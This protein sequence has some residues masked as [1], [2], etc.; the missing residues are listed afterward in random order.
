MSTPVTRRR[1]A[2]GLRLLGALLAAAVILFPL[3]WMVVVAFSTRSSLSGGGLRLWPEQATLDNFRR[4]LDSFPVLTWFGNSVAIALVTS[5]IIVLV[6]LLA[7]YAFAHLR[8]PGSGVLLL[9]ALSTLML[10]VQVIMVGLFRL[11]TD[12][13]LYGS[14][15]AVILPTAASAFG[16][17]LARQFILTIPRELIEAAR[18]DGATHL[19][20]FWRIVLPL[21]RPLIAVLFFMS[22]LQ[23]WNDFAWPLI[24]L[25]EN[26]LY[27]LPV[28]LLF[29]QGQFG[30]DY[31]A[32][33]A[34][35]L[36]TVA[37]MVLV[38]LLAQRWFVQG[39]SRSGLR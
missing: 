30:P 33:M 27:T 35:A 16:V 38:F 5:V 21:S 8:F 25:R 36:I 1:T 17:F 31:G 18:I 39:F 13:G 37:P 34:F 19:Q 6:N 32:T 29:L 24:A 2:A 10:P 11:V 7:G 3:Y 14:Y 22:M 9:V 15:W 4:V 28:G 26:A 23:V 12:L 20:I